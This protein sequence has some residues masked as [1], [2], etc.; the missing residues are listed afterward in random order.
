MEWETNMS[1]VIKN[2]LV[3]IGSGDK[4]K[5][6]AVYDLPDSAPNDSFFLKIQEYQYVP[7]YSVPPEVPQLKNSACFEVTS[8]TTL[9]GTIENCT[10][11]NTLFAFV[12][13][14]GESEF[15]A[16]DGW[17][18]LKYVPPV[19]EDTAVQG[20]ATLVKEVESFTE[21]ITITQQEAER[22]YIT[23]VEF[24]N[25]YG[26][27][28]VES[29]QQ[30]STATITS[31]K[32][33]DDVYVWGVAS[34]KW[35]TS[36]PPAWTVSPE[37]NDYIA[38]DNA[39]TQPRLGVFVDSQP[40]GERTFDPSASESFLI[41]E[42][43]SLQ[44]KEGVID[45]YEKSPSLIDVTS[46]KTVGVYYDL[47]PVGFNDFANNAINIFYSTNGTPGDIIF[48]L[49]KNNFSILTSNSGAVVNWNGMQ[50]LNY[51]V[52]LYHNG[53]YIKYGYYEMPL[54]FREQLTFDNWANMSIIDLQN[55]NIWAP[56][57]ISD[58]STEA[59]NDFNT[60]VETLDLVSWAN[61]DTTILSN[62]SVWGSLGL[63][64]GGT[65]SRNDTPSPIE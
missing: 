16:P 13:V 25:V 5:I 35:T 11:G 49:N 42:A 43:V 45:H 4:W 48:T 56:L 3:V 27:Q 21:S 32:E 30:Q 37:L 61:I 51:D 20:L 19:A 52:Y 38:L 62:L 24:E 39:T 8:D 29:A 46:I 14:R 63:A 12:I 34:S 44:G 55:L 6:S 10:L 26:Y 7:V 31:Y 57:N 41:C 23:L 28:Y 17:T 65:T 33:S 58:S 54:A 18:L 36:S 47:D 59:V 1:I 15:T 60:F 9:T 2:P 64:D 50:L 40:V 22:I 53:E